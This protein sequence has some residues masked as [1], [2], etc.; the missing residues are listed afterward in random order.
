MSKR[1]RVQVGTVHFVVTMESTTNQWCNVFQKIM[2]KN[3][4]WQK[5]SNNARPP[6][7][8]E[9]RWKASLS[10]LDAM[11]GCYQLHCLQAKI[12]YWSS[13]CYLNQLEQFLM[14]FTW[15]NVSTLNLLHTVNWEC[16][17]NTLL[18]K[19]VF[20]LFTISLYHAG[21]KHSFVLLGK[22]QLENGI[23]KPCVYWMNCACLIHK[24]Y[25]YYNKDVYVQTDRSTTKQ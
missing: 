9:L 18:A 8:S 24:L 11:F 15:K 4:T 2:G 10:V 3:K 13:M 17:D 22:W 19:F 14:C 5:A 7:P 23:H 21:L 25:G 12:A 1:C 6:K 16:C 20:T